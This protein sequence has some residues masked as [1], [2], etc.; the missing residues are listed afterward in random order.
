MEFK[1]RGIGIAPLAPGPLGD[2]GVDV[3]CFADVVVDELF[4]ERR[5]EVVGDFG[6]SVGKN[7]R[8]INV[9]G[10]GMDAHPRHLVH[11]REFVLVVRLVLVEHDGQVEGVVDL[12][13]S[14]RFNDGKLLR[15]G[16]VGNVLCVP[17]MGEG[18]GTVVAGRVLHREGGP[19]VAFVLPLRV[20]E[21]VKGRGLAQRRPGQSEFSGFVVGPTRIEVHRGGLV[22][23]RATV[24]GNVLEVGVI[25]EDKTVVGCKRKGVSKTP[26]PGENGTA[27]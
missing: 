1:G 26:I 18:L 6:V 2:V 27:L 8:R 20:D 14:A 4:D 9:F 16:R 17:S 11:P 15:S 3:Q 22:G 5:Y 10:H 23:P 13:C 21:D 19:N 12:L 24:V 25:F 7:T